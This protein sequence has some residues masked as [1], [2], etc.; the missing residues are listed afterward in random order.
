MPGEALKSSTASRKP[1]NRG[2]AKKLT[3]KQA[4]FIDEYLLDFNATQAA[5]RAGFPPA[6]AHVQAHRL[7]SDIKVFEEVERRKQRVATKFEVTR[8]MIIAEQ[9]KIGFANMGDYAR[10][11]GDALVTDFS[12]TTRD[13]LA[14]VQEIT[15][16]VYMEG[17][18]EDAQPV[19]KI[20]FK[21]ADKGRALEYLGRQFGLSNVNVKI[22]HSVA[23]LDLTS[24]SDEDLDQL[25]AAALLLENAG[26]PVIEGEFSETP[27]EGSDG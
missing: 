19:K 3:P 20:K 5:I 21:L 14:A 15:T 6:G 17:K 23:P 2:T 8:E 24:M 22:E 11:H 16:E 12:K 18:G 10:I 25:E 26:A 13:Q 27:K 1:K 4:R 9:M 7:L